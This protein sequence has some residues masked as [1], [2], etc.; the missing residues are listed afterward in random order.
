MDLKRKSLQG[1]SNI[2]WFNRHFYLIALLVLTVLFLLKNQFPPLIQILLNVGIVGAIFTLMVSLLVSYFVYDL[3]DLYQLKWIKNADNKKV[4]NINAGFDE[5]S[6]I[7]ITKFP[8]TDLTIC[9]F[10]DPNKHPEIS[11]K[12]ARRAYPP[13]ART[14]SVSTNQLPFSENTFDK[15]IV[16]LSAH[17]IRNQDE[18][19]QFF[20]ELNRVTKSS[21]QIFVTE[22]L[23]DLNNLMAYTIGVFHFYSRKSW[24]QT[25]KEADLIVT[26]EIK[27]TPF[28]IT[29][30]LDKNGNTL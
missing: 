5:T 25:F 13:S 24:L 16:I 27:T 6:D 8:E 7:I 12:R 4:L 11:I 3:S 23:R 14:I 19:A 28:I 20:K 22:H 26:E 2:I 29:F 21:G 30:V 18:R 9:D 10:Y 1:V 17:E 15:T